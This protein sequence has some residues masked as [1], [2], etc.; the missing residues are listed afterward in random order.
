MGCVWEERDIALSMIV[1]IMMVDFAGLCI[2]K[3]VGSTTANVTNT[4]I[5]NNMNVD[6]ESLGNLAVPTPK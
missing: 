3:F 5:P 6:T 4:Y 2:I 1:L